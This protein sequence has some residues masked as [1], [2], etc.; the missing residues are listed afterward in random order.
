MNENLA[1]KI[2]MREEVPIKSFSIAAYICKEE[3][4]IY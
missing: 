3:N 4:A 2:D 1:K